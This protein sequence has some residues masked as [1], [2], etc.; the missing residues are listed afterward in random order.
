MICADTFWAVKSYPEVPAGSQFRFS[1]ADTLKRLEPT[2]AENGVK[3]VRY[4]NPLD[5]GPVA[6]ERRK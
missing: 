5:G 1:W 2:T 6:I 3:T 4:T